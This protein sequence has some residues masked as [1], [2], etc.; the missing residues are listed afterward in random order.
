VSRLQHKKG[1]KSNYALS[2]N[3]EYWNEVKSIIRARDRKCVKCG[4]ILYL[5]VHHIR[6]YV[7]CVSII[8]NEK[9]HLNE[10]ILLCS[11]CHELEHKNKNNENTNGG[12][13]K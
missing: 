3:S 5:E 12:E 2:L 11:K 10:L 9:K 6:Y 13:S 7:N 1:R 4:S 8:G